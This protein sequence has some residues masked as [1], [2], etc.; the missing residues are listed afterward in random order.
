[1]KKK[2]NSIEFDI[3]VIHPADVIA[4]SQDAVINRSGGLNGRQALAPEREFDYYEGY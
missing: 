1:M 4:T 3:V 2:Y